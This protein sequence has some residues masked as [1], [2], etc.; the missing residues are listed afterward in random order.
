TSYFE[1]LAHGPGR[2]YFRP[3]CWPNTPDILT[4]Y[5]QFG[6]RPAFIVRLALAATLAASYGMYGPVFELMEHLPREAGSEEYLDSEKYQLRRWDLDRPDSLVAII[7]RVNR[8]RRDYPALQ[9]DWN[10]KFFGTD[11]DQLLCYGK[12]TADQQN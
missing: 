3:N 11:S 7:G 6:G 12:V 8:A 5:L 4:E 10:L 2:E 1:E 9:Q